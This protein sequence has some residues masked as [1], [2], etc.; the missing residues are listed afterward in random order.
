MDE[1]TTNGRSLGRPARRRMWSLLPVAL[2]LVAVVALAVYRKGSGHQAASAQ[3]APVAISQQ[4]LEEEYGLSIRLLAV[5]A[6]GGLIDLRFKVVDEAKAAQLLDTSQLRLGI[7]AQESDTLIE[8]PA[9]TRQS[10]DLQQDMVY[11][12]QF[13]NTGHAIDVGSRVSLIMGDVRV[14]DLVAQ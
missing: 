2:L 10:F 6:A 9:D 14:D 4:T 8:A 3:P 12:V 1:I 7:V 13:P 5:T 11:F